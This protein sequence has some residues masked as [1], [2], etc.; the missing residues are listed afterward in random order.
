MRNTYS[1]ST[2]N[3]ENT[4]TQNGQILKDTPTIRKNSKRPKILKTI[5][6][7][8]EKLHK[9]YR[10]N[11]EEYGK[12][13]HEYIICVVHFANHFCPYLFFVVINYLCS[14][15]CRGVTGS[16]SLQLLVSS[17]S[18]SSTFSF[19]VFA[20][21]AHL[22]VATKFPAYVL[23]AYRG[24]NGYVRFIEEEDDDDDDGDD[25]NDDE[26]QYPPQPLHSELL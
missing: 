20:G 11:T 1:K 16:N 22:G 19:S 17:Q 8:C 2:E 4:T 14:V 9:I 15:R 10:T 3:T 7:N 5:R 13:C 6:N 21:S 26:W 25:D 18:P 12:N 24:R 23:T